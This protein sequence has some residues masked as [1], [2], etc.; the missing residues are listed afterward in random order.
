MTENNFDESCV[1]T[2][3]IQ[4]TETHNYY[5]VPCFVT[6]FTGN[7]SPGQNPIIIANLETIH[8]FVKGPYES[9]ICFNYNRSCTRIQPINS[10]SICI[11]KNFEL[12]IN[13]ESQGIDITN[14][15]FQYDIISDILTKFQIIT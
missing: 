1:W 14:A 8:C 13:L 12:I 2:A 15:Q 11:V 3:R 10:C 6:T 9:H 5:C 4:D 7:A